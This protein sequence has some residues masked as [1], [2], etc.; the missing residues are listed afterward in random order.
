[1]T[2]KTF[3]T[4]FLK[5][6]GLYLIWQTLI[7][8]PSFFSTLVY[9]FRSDDKLSVFTALCAIVVIG[10]TFALIFRTCLFKTDFLIK[11]LRLDKGFEDETVEI[12]IHRSSLLSIATIVIGGLMLADGLP[13][14]VF[15]GFQYIQRDSAYA[16]FGRNPSSP[17]LVTNFLKIVIGYFMVADSR[18]IINFIERKRKKAQITD[19]ESSI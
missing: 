11:K 10:C 1:M 6:F 19:E 18:L 13:L 2:P 17:W 16:T 14:L 15:Y 9:M 5:I 4:F 3:W 12:N 7:L 8:L